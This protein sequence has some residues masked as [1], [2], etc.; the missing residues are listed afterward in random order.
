MKGRVGTEMISVILV[1]LLSGTEARNVPTQVDRPQNV[2]GDF[3]S[4]G[5]IPGMGVGGGLPGFFNGVPGLGGS[6]LSNPPVFGLGGTPSLLDP[7]ALGGSFPGMLNPPQLGLGGSPN[8]FNPP[9]LGIPSFG[10]MP[11]NGGAV[12]RDLHPDLVKS[13]NSP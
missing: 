7:P 9:T 8:M 13:S 5:G 6:G 2:P 4:L 12:P 11:G 3:G 1:F 10:F